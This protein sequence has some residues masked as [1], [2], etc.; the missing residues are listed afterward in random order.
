MQKNS[1]EQFIFKGVMTSP[2]YIICI[3]SL[4]LSLVLFYLY[5]EIGFR[6]FGRLGMS[7]TFLILGIIIFLMMRFFLAKTMIIYFDPGSIYIGEQNKKPKRYL[8]SD[9][10]GFYSY[11]YERLER[12][13]ISIQIRFKNGKKISLTDTVMSERVEMDK[14]QMLQRFLRTAKKQLNFT[15]VKK[16]RARSLQKLGAC[17]YSDSSNETE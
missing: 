5:G 13:F 9:I 10:D 12:S 3:I 17:W 4:V 8:K 2:Y 6:Y 1:P 15:Y 7:F 16:N 14:A 11:D